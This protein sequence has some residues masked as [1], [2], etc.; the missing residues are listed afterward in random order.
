MAGRFEYICCF[1]ATACVFLAMPFCAAQFCSCIHCLA[2]K[3]LEDGGIVSILM[4]LLLSIVK[5]LHFIDV[6]LDRESHM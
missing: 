3:F 2:V 6:T 5:F 1:F 4:L